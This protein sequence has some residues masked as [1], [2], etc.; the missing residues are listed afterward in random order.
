MWGGAAKRGMTGQGRTGR[1]QASALAIAAGLMAAGAVPAQTIDTVAGTLSL[2]AGYGGDGGPAT[3]AQLDR[4]F[5]VAVDGK[6][7]VFIAD[8]IFNVIREFAVGGTITTVAGTPGLTGSF[9]GDGGAATAATLD[10][11]A[12]IAVDASGNV[13][14]AD[15][16]NRRIRMFTPGGTITTV[17]GGGGTSGADGLG[18][19][20]PAVAASLAFPQGVAVDASGNVYVADTYDHL[21]RMF[22]VGGTISVVAGVTDSSGYGGDGG[23]ATSALLAS[24]AAVAVDGAGHVYIADN[25]SHV[26]RAFTVGGTIATVAGTPQKFGY[27]GDGGPA[28]AALLHGPSGV[29][30]DGAGN[31]YI[32]DTENGVIRKVAGGVLT[33]IA[34]GGT[35]A[36]SD[37]VGDGGPAPL[38]TLSSPAT[39]VPD[40][41]GNLLVADTGNDLIRSLSATV[42]APSLVAAVLPGARSVVDT[43]AATIFAT[44]VNA[45]GAALNNCQVELPTAASRQLLL[46]YQTTDPSTNALTGTADT[47]VSIAANGLQT[48]LLSFSDT[49]N[50]GTVFSDPGQ[51]LFFA[52]DGVDPA[53]TTQ[54]VNTVD[55][56]F[57]PTPVADIIALA[58]VSGDVPGTLDFPTSGAGA[59]AVAS[60]NVGSADTLT[61]SVDTGS[62]A[63]PLT[64]TLCP[65]NASAQCTSTPAASVSQSFAAGSSP[66]FSVFA[67]ASAPVAFAPATSR[68]FVRFTDSSGAS[69]GS[70]SVAVETQ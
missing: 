59:F 27:A 40:G 9:S 46:D 60:D 44:M 14:V 6:G 55:L 67:T 45:T 1:L 29:S 16:G 57:S 32:A 42:P 5:S 2:A 25:G 20:G 17:A 3:S 41:Q 30:V 66:T 56:S 24:P 7:D 19:G 58:A 13:Y 63:L 53:A 69:H 47:P 26:I 12:G 31:L 34:G 48:F 62:A 61:V 70:T 35:N 4:P 11:P 22:T 28:T 68:I 64:L 36:G 18:D 52:C 39:V 8:Q 65:T 43:G 33:T 51:Q 10:G 49:E 23:P 50:T 21:V 37:G 54:G 38:A 15:A